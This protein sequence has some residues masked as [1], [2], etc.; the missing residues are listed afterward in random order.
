MV[1]GPPVPPLMID[2]FTQDCDCQIN[3]LQPA[4][5]R[6]ALIHCRGYCRFAEDNQKILE[7]LMKVYITEIV[8][9]KA[10]SRGFYGQIEKSVFFS[11][12]G[13]RSTMTVTYRMNSECINGQLGSSPIQLFEQLLNTSYG[14]GTVL[15][16]RMWTSF[17]KAQPSLPVH[18]RG[19]CLGK[20]NLEILHI[21]YRMMALL[22]AGMYKH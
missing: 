1:P 7:E 17:K 22:I 3:G 11:H 15:V 12:A 5:C 21:C 2:F 4:P 20:V 18:V 8:G 10:R 9:S 16:F 6:Q 14:P 19:Q 13:I